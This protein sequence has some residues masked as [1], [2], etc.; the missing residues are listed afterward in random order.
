M[1][2]CFQQ[3][4]DIAFSPFACYRLEIIIIFNIFFILW[5]YGFAEWLIRSFI[6][7]LLQAKIFL[8]HWN[9][10]C[11]F[12]RLK[13]NFLRLPN[14]PGI[15]GQS[16]RCRGLPGH[17]M[18]GELWPEALRLRPFNHWKAFKPLI[19]WT[20]IFFWKTVPWTIHQTDIRL[21]LKKVNLD[22][23]A[24]VRPSRSIDDVITFWKKV[25]DPELYNWQ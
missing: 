13:A 15:L 14:S 2:Y 16:R 21:W 17:R 1:F 3:F 25:S 7:T 8:N 9:L 4:L 23:V 19:I 10:F 24:S 22:R 20:E 12:Y 11:N 5:F 6:V 18:N